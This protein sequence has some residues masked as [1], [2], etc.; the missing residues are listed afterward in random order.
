MNEMFA[1]MVRLSRQMF[2]Q[3]VAFIAPM[4]AQVV[5]LLWEVNLAGFRI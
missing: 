5:A 3:K 2:A 4:F 1:Q